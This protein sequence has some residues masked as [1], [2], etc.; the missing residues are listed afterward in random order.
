MTQFSH[1]ASEALWV[2]FFSSHSRLLLHHVWHDKWN[3]QRKMEEWKEEEESIFF[4]RF[5]AEEMLNCCLPPPPLWVMPARVHPWYAM[6]A[7]SLLFPR[8]MAGCS[9][10]AQIVILICF[11]SFA[12][13]VAA[14]ICTVGRETLWALQASL[15]MLSLVID[16]SRR[17]RCMSRRFSWFSV[18]SALALVFISKTAREE[19]RRARCKCEEKLQS[20]ITQAFA[21]A[22]SQRRLNLLSRPSQTSVS[23]FE[24]SREGRESDVLR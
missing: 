12:S 10:L 4:R 9:L 13:S 14:I 20:A 18:L 2:I 17:E 6:N 21:L 15:C 16:L 3:I 5:C 11:I 1:G 8:R 7:L 24:S 22:V 19:K 23:V